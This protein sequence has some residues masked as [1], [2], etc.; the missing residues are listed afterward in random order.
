MWS[1]QQRRLGRE[2]AQGWEP[3]LGASVASPAPTWVSG[4]RLLGQQHRSR[5]SS[6]EAGAHSGLSQE[7]PSTQ[8]VEAGPGL[9]PE[10][11]GDRSR[12]LP[13]LAS[14]PALASPTLGTGSTAFCASPA[15]PGALGA[16]LSPPPLQTGLSSRPPQGGKPPAPPQTPQ[17]SQSPNTCVT[18]RENLLA[19]EEG[20]GGHPAVVSVVPR[21]AWR[22]L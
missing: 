8:H 11:S 20:H 19:A 6:V 1:G 7:G 17:E 2:L 5:H 18:R 15:V 21:A 10:A 14:A 22:A 12:L 4:W 3:T 13:T 16:G 9:C